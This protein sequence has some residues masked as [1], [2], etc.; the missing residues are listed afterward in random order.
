M[1][2][3]SRFKNI[4]LLLILGFQVIAYPIFDRNHIMFGVC[5]LFYYLLSEYNVLVLKKYKY[6]F[7]MFFTYFICM[8]CVYREDYHFYSNNDSF[9]N[10]KGTFGYWF[11]MTISYDKMVNKLENYLSFYMNDFDNIYVYSTD[12]HELDYICKLDLGI[13]ID[14]F[15]LI[16]NGNMGYNGGKRRILELDNVCKNS[17]CLFLIDNS[18]NNSFSQIDENFI[19][20]VVDSYD[21]IRIIDED[22]SFTIYG[23]R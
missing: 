11:D 6:Y 15:D 22:I 19:K 21:K 14:N 1:I 23:N 4:N 2:I 7:I 9:L 10:G 5:L 20:Y 12:I 16:L 17:S 18:N 3:K 13:P 8:C